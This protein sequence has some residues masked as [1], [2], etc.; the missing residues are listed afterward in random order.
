MRI[1]GLVSAYREGTLLRECQRS[2]KECCAEVRVL[3]GPIG[4]D[5]YASDAAK[6]TEL[7]HWAQG[8]GFEW[9]VI[10]DGD[11]V[12]LWPRMLPAVIERMIEESDEPN[13]PVAGVPLRLVELDG[14]VSFVYTRVLRVDLFSRYELSSSMLVTKAGDVVGHGNEQ[15]TLA[16]GVPMPLA[17]IEVPQSEAM[18][19]W[20]R[21]LAR[22]RPPLQGEPHIL[23][24]AAYRS[25][26]RDVE[27]QHLAE[28][29]GHAEREL[30]STKGES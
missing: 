18:E 2:L 29:R 10:L 30:Q 17:P 9:A 7:L 27:R 19:R 15:L 4:P 1:C 3:D 14:S 13:A 26:S 8:K 28:A 21:H 20:Q 22:F 23:H 6:R 5:G 25:K 11:E 12:L 24:R 16:G